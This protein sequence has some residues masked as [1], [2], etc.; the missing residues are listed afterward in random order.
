VHLFR[1]HSER[2][3]L[4]QIFRLVV[5][6]KIQVERGS[7]ASE[8][9]QTYLRKVV[10]L[11]SSPLSNG[12]QQNQILDAVQEFEDIVAPGEREDLLAA[13]E[14][15]RGNIL[16]GISRITESKD[17][18]SGPIVVMGSGNTVLVGSSQRIGEQRMSNFQISFGDNAVVHGDF[19]VATTIQNSFNKAA[20]S[21]A[22]QDVKDQLKQLHKRLQR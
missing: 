22:K 12:F 20:N 5:E 15:I 18:S 9:L 16:R 17:V 14:S 11:L 10:G 3:S 19:V 8:T 7:T 6:K 4:K 1:L 13:L 2:Q 21:P